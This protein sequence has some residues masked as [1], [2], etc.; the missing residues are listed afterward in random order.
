MS[1]EFLYQTGDP[2]FAQVPDGGE[3]VAGEELARLGATGITAGYRGLYFHA[4]RDELYRIVYGAL[5]L[6]R[7]LC[8]LIRFQCHNPEYLYRRTQSID[9][10]SIFT[11]RRT[12]A[13]F[14]T[15]ANSAIRHSQYAALTV[16]DAIV[17]QFRDRTGQRPNVEPQNP[18]LW[19]SLY[20]H[21]NRATI[22]LDLSGGA[23]HRRGYRVE[24]IEAP[25]QETVAAVMLA[26]TGWDGSVPLVDPMCGSGT[27]L[28][29]ALMRYCRIPAAFLRPQQGVRFLPDFDAAAW[30][31]V[32]K[33]C[34][35]DIRPLP[36]GL[37][38]GSDASRD[39]VHAARVNLARLPG[40]RDVAVDACRYENIEH[41][42]ESAIV[43][44]PPYG[45]RIGKRAA[46]PEFVRN[47]G[48]FL[49]HRCTGSTAFIYFGDR[50]LIKS[51]GLRP[52]FKKPLANGGLDGRVVKLE[53]FPG[54]ARN[55]PK[56]LS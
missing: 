12:F 46:M 29:E 44:N 4:G 18:D 47:L 21:A 5:T 22:S 36:P 23:M 41:I 15:V 28:C 43:T 26:M 54:K 56:D 55:S 13:V 27:I 14:A 6:S 42:A 16:K 49:K 51:I 17:D 1:T 52:A 2:F 11:T 38:R 53:M 40:G 48:D 9:W 8:P 33:Q 10:T 30:E 24:S 45:L 19:I 7:V 32:K 50:E 20:L 37:I 39:A 34:D 31:S 3:E 25:M 35:A